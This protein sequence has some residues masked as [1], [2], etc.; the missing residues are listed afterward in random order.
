MRKRGNASS[1]VHVET[2]VALRRQGGRAGVKSHPDANR[3]V[4][5]S[6]NR[7][8][9]GSRC[10]SRRREGD[11]EGVTL[12]VHLDPAVA[13]ITSRRMLRCSVSASA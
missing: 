13:A 11:E 6:L 2:D 3:A 8:P 5:K 12:R 4:G 10:S 7:P 1:A 9:C